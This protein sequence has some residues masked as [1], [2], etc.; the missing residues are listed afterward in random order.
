MN[1]RSDSDN[2][3]KQEGLAAKMSVARRNPLQSQACLSLGDRDGPQRPVTPVS[4]PSRAE[5]TRTHCGNRQ[6]RPLDVVY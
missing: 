2:G 1:P 3:P 5:P 4:L 6:P